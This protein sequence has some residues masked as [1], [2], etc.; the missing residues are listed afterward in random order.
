MYKIWNS[1]AVN[2]SEMHCFQDKEWMI[3]ILRTELAV[4]FLL[5]YHQYQAKN[6]IKSFKNMYVIYFYRVFVCK[7]KMGIHVKK[8]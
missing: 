1:C 2:L 8:Q 7:K 4:I 3:N 6:L 5:E